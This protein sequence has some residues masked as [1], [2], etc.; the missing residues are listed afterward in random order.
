MSAQGMSITGLHLAVKVIA[1]RDLGI[2][3]VV[4]TLPRAT[5]LTEP[6]QKLRAAGN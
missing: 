4:K 1:A 2:L 6:C 3:A 5:T